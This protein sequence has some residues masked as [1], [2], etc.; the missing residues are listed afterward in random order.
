MCRISW[1]DSTASKLQLCEPD[2]ASLY[3]WWNITSFVIN[4][5]H[6]VKLC[7]SFRV[8]HIKISIMACSSYWVST[9]FYTL[10][11]NCMRLYIWKTHH[12]SLCTWIFSFPNAHQPL[13]YFLV[14]LLCH[15]AMQCT[16]L[17][18]WTYKN[19]CNSVKLPSAIS[20]AHQKPGYISC[21]MVSCFAEVFFCSIKV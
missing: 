15:Y 21:D 7:C 11:C 2:R 1:S 17:C 19:L 13:E 16:S 4:W 6:S 18:A 10:H 8:Q 5:K 9:S 12:L 3:S 20:L 14:L